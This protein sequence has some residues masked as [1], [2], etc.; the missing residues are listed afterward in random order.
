MRPGEWRSPLSAKMVAKAGVTVSWPQLVGSDIWWVETRPEDG[1]RRVIVSQQRGDLIDLP[2]SASHT[3]HEMSGRSYLGEANGDSYRIYFS[4]R[5]DQ[6][7]YLKDGDGAP[8][9]ITPDTNKADRYA[10]FI[11]IPN[12]IWCV[13]EQVK[14]GVTRRQ[15]IEVLD[16]GEIRI[17]VTGHQFIA[18]PRISPNGKY[19]SWIAWDHPFMPWDGTR[20]FI[21]E[22]VNGEIKNKRAVAG[23][24]TNPVLSPEWLDENTII[25]IDE[26]SGWWNPWQVNVEGVRHQIINEESEWGFPAWQLGYQGIAILDSQHFLGIHGPVDNRRFA[27]VNLKDKSIKDIDSHFSYFAPT[28]NSNGKRLV[29]FAASNSDFATL[30]EIDL[31]KRKIKDVIRPNPL[32][33]PK[34]YAPRIF[35]IEIP[36]DSHNIKVILHSAQNPEYKADGPTPLLIHVHG[37]PTGHEF[38]VADLDFLYWTTR[39]FTIADINHG[40]SS[41]YG[42]KYRHLLYGNWGVLDYQDVLTTVKYLIE[43]KIADP[44]R[45]FISGGSAGGFTVL[46]SIIHSDLFAAGADYY[47]VAELSAL[48]TDTHDFESRYL[49][50]MIGPYPEKTDLYK[51]RSPLTHADKLSTPLIIFQGTEDPIVPPSQSEM[52]RDVCIKKGIT[53]KYFEFQGEAHG[54]VKAESL[55]TSLEETLKFFGA[56]GDFSPVP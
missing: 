13:R 39:G 43:S 21:A 36:T 14:D 51:E 12:G 55:I 45:V 16:S 5:A 2:F 24:D 10:E 35:E 32:P 30:V 28:F 3:V 48:A 15:L 37:G 47:G 11:K 26:E 49:D 6:R 1:G 56:A 52:F 46:N 22:I 54:F 23:S 31:I 38:A 33:I 34:E 4:N 8:I 19:L 27:I 42:A 18:H 50:S 41:G 44:K 20:L 9:P 53:H 29:A 17:L 25:Y 7:I 40:G